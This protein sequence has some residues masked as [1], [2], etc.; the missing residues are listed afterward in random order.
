MS[1][2]HPVREYYSRLIRQV[3]RDAKT[4]GRDTLFALLIGI[5]IL[6]LQVRYGMIRTD[7]TW[8]GALSVIYPYLGLLGL[9]LSYQAIKA[10]YVL[11]KAVRSELADNIA[12]V[13]KKTQRAYLRK[14]LARFIEDGQLLLRRCSFG[15]LNPP[16]DRGRRWIE[17]TEE[18]VG[19][20][21]GE[22]AL[23]VYRVKVL[24]LR[25]PDSQTI[26]TGNSEQ[27]QVFILLK[28]RL[29]RLT[30]FL[31]EVSGE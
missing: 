11:D 28:S 31:L 6:L 17:N 27:Q 3:Y 25:Y 1:S 8:R 5:T 23:E 9:Y 19:K 22:S 20:N 18:F 14:E 29:Q 30:D 12:A 21:L 10:P 16:V 2:S 7:Q 24:P 13:Q 26:L 15:E 4:F